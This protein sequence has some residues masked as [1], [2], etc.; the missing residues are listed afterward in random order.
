MQ[1]LCPPSAILT[2]NVCKMAGYN[3]SDQATLSHLSSKSPR[4]G[5]AL[6]LTMLVLNHV[7]NYHVRFSV[8]GLF[9]KHA[10]K[11]NGVTHQTTN[12]WT[13]SDGYTTITGGSLTI[14]LVY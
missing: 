13:L 11:Q 14:L 6:Q 9:L 5:R 3:H 7:F 12:K 4:K 2:L 1:P 10:Y 8:G